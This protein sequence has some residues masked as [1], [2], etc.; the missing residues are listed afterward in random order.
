MPSNADISKI[1]CLTSYQVVGEELPAELITCQHLNTSA[2]PVVKR[3]VD[4][5]ILI[6]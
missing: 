5:P 6:V 2:I 1:G 3:N 4:I